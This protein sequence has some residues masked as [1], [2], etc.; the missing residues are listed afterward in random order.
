MLIKNA[1]DQSVELQ[2]LGQRAAST[3]SRACHFNPRAGGAHRTN[4][5]RIGA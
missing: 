2:V 5:R 4:L 3:G 1:D